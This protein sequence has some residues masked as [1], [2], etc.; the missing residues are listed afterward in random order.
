MMADSDAVAAGNG[1][2]EVDSYTVTYGH[3]KVKITREGA[4][5]L[6]HAQGGP[7]F[8]AKFSDGDH[9]AMMSTAVEYARRLDQAQQKIEAA[10]KDRDDIHA[11]LGSAVYADGP[12]RYCGDTG[13]IGA[14]SNPGRRHCPACNPKGER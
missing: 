9:Q 14:E 13:I 5:W 2:I 3:T 11:W 7:H 4:M 6:V 1:H 8:G 12:C 10:Q